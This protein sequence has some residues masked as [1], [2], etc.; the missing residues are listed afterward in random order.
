MDG[1]SIETRMAQP[2]STTATLGHTRIRLDE[3]PPLERAGATPN[4]FAG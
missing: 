4:A 3:K 2:V 1:M